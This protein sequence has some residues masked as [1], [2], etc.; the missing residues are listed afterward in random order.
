MRTPISRLTTALAVPLLAGS[1]SAQQ[2]SQSSLVLSVGLG[3]HTGHGL[4]TIPSQP[5]ALLNANPPVYDSLRLVRSI[6]PGIMATVSGTYFP[7]AYVGVNGSVTFLDMSME[8]ACRPVGPYVV[9]FQEKN[10]QTCENLDGTVSSNSA[11]VLGLGVT[12]RAAPRGGASPYLRAGIGYAIHSSG[13]IGMSST[14]V[15]SGSQI[16]RQILAEESPLGGSFAGQFGVGI[17]QPFASGYQLRL[18]VRDDFMGFEQAAG[19]ANALG[20]LPTGRGW[21]HHWALTIGLDIVL[22]RTRARRY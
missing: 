9:D 21:Y 18:E 13:T 22:E 20:Q 2:A 1:L 3:V 7:S 16:S 8:N 14:Y 4:W 15:V 11:I 6:S 19:P 10:R 17:T 5:L 12:L